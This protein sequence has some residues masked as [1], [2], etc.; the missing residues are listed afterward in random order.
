MKA[1][2]VDSYGGPLRYDEIDAPELAPGRVLVDIAY[3]GVNPVDVKFCDGSMRQF[4]DWDLPLVPGYDFAGTVV[5]VADDVRGFEAGDEIYASCLDVTGSRGAFAEQIVI[6]AD[7]IALKPKSISLAEAAALPVAVLTTWQSYYDVGDLQT[8]S[9]V[10]VHAGAGGVGS[11]AIQIAKWAGCTVLT[12]ASAAN[13]DYVKSLGADVA[14]DY[15]TERFVDTVK[16]REPAGVDFV[17]DCAGGEALEGSFEVLKPGGLLAGIVE[18]PDAA[19]AQ[20]RG[21]TASWVGMVAN[22]AQLQRIT[23]LIDDGALRMPEIEEMPLA[24]AGRA[25]E[26]ISGRHVRGKIVLNIRG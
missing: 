17:L 14:I 5:D 3:A 9:T 25:F 11:M 6:P 16:S 18:V 24:D 20:A 15:R 21:A 26:R 10:L 19:R 8:G 13:H 7:A 1:I 2:Y 4:F 12:T 23:E 22:G